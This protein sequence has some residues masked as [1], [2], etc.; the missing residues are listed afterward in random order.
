M[1]GGGW[2]HDC[3]ACPFLKAS[4]EA[5]QQPR[6][7]PRGLSWV[8][9]WSGQL[10]G[11]VRQP[12]WVSLMCRSVARHAHQSSV[13]TS[14]SP[15]LFRAATYHFMPRAPDKAVAPLVPP[16]LSH[17]ATHVSVASLH[18]DVHPRLPGVMAEHPRSQK[19][20]LQPLKAQQQ[21]SLHSLWTEPA[22][23][24]LRFKEENRLY[25]SL[26]GG[27]LDD[28]GGREPACQCRR[29]KRCRFDPW[30]GKIPWK[31]KW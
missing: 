31:G 20:E 22:T 4:Q 17:P 2:K 24:Q 14:G 23:C 11:S 28:A 15:L 5:S 13:A 3:P 7:H 19:Q 6:V 8:Y 12:V 16:G 25:L 1:A 29:R 26:G 18:I 27:F 9:P 10:Q 21:R 30:V